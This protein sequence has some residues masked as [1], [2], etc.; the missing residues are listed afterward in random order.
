[1]VDLLLYGDGAFAG[2][3]SISRVHRKRVSR[4]RSETKS[5]YYQ[6]KPT[7]RTLTT[8]MET[9]TVKERGMLFSTPMVQA[10][11]RG[12]KTQTRRIVKP[13]NLPLYDDGSI[14]NFYKANPLWKAEGANCP[15]GE[16]GEVIWVRETWAISPHM[17]ADQDWVDY[18]YKADGN[19]TPHIDPW[20]K[21]KW[22]PSLFMPKEACRIRLEITSVRVEK[23]Q[24]ISEEDAVAE[25][26]GHAFAP[27]DGVMWKNYL[28]NEYWPEISPIDSYKTL[29]MSING[30]D[31]WALNPW[32]FVIN[33]RRI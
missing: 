22:K 33:F 13:I 19:C 32:V 5:N 16:K 15:H 17:F 29:W 31:S 3:G 20:D 1:M 8:L 21:I 23:L 28:A 4:C 7:L 26:I 12:D 24:D 25:G 30:K 6:E 9:T 10:I 14:D 27:A 11:V 18:I 2:T